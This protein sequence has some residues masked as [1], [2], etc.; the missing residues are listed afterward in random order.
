MTFTKILGKYWN[1][2]F[3]LSPFNK[4]ISREP[5][6]YQTVRTELNLIKPQRNDI[7]LDKN[8][9]IKKINAAI[10]NPIQ[11]FFHFKREK[12]IYLSGW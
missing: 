3:F 8:K 10:E 9:I 12:N 6:I 7:I 1:I 4:S 11:F 5:S 2:S